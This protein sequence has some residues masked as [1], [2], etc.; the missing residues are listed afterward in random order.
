MIEVPQ[1]AQYLSPPM[2]QIEGMI[3]SRRIHHDG[4]P[5]L[6]WCLSN[7]EVKED[8]NE[9]IF[10]RKA[11]GRSEAKIDAGVAL[12]MAVRYATELVPKATYTWT[13]EV[14]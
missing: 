12:I 7:I 8:Y 5:I 1:R 6:A 9:N 4:D 2:R 13:A 3:K 10:P 11:G 14:W